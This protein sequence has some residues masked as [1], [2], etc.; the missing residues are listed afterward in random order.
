MGIVVVHF[1]HWEPE[2]NLPCLEKPAIRRNAIS[3]PVASHLQQ[4][5]LTVPQRTPSSSAAMIE[6]H[7]YSGFPLP[8]GRERLPKG[9]N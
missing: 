1:A 3:A 6:R 7:L 4:S 2:K 9:D 5:C 8:N